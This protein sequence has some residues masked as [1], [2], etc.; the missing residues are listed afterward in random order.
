MS[1]SS[2]GSILFSAYPLLPVSDESC[3]GAEQILWSV[4]REISLRGHKT[5]VAACESSR[6]SGEL[7]S[8]GKVPLGDDRFELREAEHSV[9][10]ISFAREK[11]SSI[12]HDHSGSFWKHAAQLTVPV[13]ATLHLPRA[14][15]A[16]SAFNALPNNVYF[17]CVSESQAASFRD[18][19]RMMPVVQNGIDVERFKMSRKKDEYL[20]WLGRICPEKAP[21]LAIEAAKRA[22]MKLVLAGQV[23]PFSYHKMYFENEVK[24]L[25]EGR[26]SNVEFIELPTFE[27]KV[28]L[29]RCAKALLVTSLIP[30]T[31]SLVAM[32]AGACGTPV[33]AF[34]NGALSE[35]VQHGYT[36]FT[37]RSLDDMVAAI[38]D[39]GDIWPDECRHNVETKFSSKAMADGYERLYRRVIEEHR[40]TMALAA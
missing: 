13:L 19:P 5:A 3:G 1:N 35:V 25:I 17:N 36:G 23:Y 27:E 28:D 34:R 8:T 38:R 15:Y 33:V 26:N 21:H 39:V 37:V 10:I 40:E 20:L 9:A 18:L 24:P 4:E 31:S 32:E 2:Q 14:L 11:K 22:G 16:E 12:V 7:L 6:V 30:E 29:L